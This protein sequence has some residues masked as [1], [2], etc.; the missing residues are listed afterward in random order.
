MTFGKTLLVTLGIILS[1]MLDSFAQ[2]KNDTTRT[3]IELENKVE[4]LE[5]R[6]DSLEIKLQESREAMITQSDLE[7]IFR[8]MNEDDQEF[9]NESRRSK[10]RVLDSL[11]RAALG[12]QKQ[13]T[14]TGQF[15]TVFHW[16][17]EIEN[18]INTLVGT[19]DLFAISSFGR[20]NLAF[21]NLQGLGGE[22]PGGSFES[23]HG[24]H[25]GASG[26]QR[27]YVLEAW[28]EFNLKGVGITVGKIDLTNY[29]D[30]NSVANDEYTQFVS[31]GF[32]NS[33]ALAI[34]G[35]GPGIVVNSL[36]MNNLSLQVAISNTKDSLN[37][38]FKEIF[39]IFQIG[40]SFN[41]NES[42]IGGI[43]FYAYHDPSVMQGWGYGASGDIRLLPHLYAFGRYGTNLEN[44]GLD[45][46]ID[47]SYSFGLQL[48]KIEVLQKMIFTTGIGFSE[49][50]TSI[51]ESD[52][53]NEQI[54][55]AY[56][57]FGINKRFYISPLYQRIKNGAGKLNN[58][59]S[60]IGL[61]A[62][63]VF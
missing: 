43:R 25:A 29:F 1:M 26:T 31:N 17:G 19:V 27:V 30:P 60:V 51:P 11:F 44:L 20:S 50:K 35:N 21:I 33:S 49:N 54:I 63:L 42:R 14:L 52:Q 24:F 4:K 55:E 56:F 13:L 15:M 8:T 38:I 5:R 9:T 2:E 39:S 37:E 22:G 10:R 47:N 6:L 46:G 16:D 57:R 7:N 45:F 62:R 36:L 48:R 18:S 34:P 53:A 40:K 61:R 23:F 32:V 12:R 59:I 28:T 3:N 41:F 58:E